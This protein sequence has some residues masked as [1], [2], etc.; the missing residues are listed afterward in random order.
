MLLLG[1]PVSTEAILSSYLCF[2]LFNLT[3]LMTLNVSLT[4]PSVKTKSW[5]GKNI[6]IKPLS[7][8]LEVSSNGRQGPQLL[9]VFEA[10]SH[11]GSDTSAPL[12]LTLRCHRDSPD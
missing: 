5:K 6:F 8:S 12:S 10:F 7:S 2:L 9:P 4:S 11:K 3:S 1:N